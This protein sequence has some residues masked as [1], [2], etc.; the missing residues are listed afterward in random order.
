MWPRA[1]ILAPHECC[2]CATA[3]HFH[4]PPLQELTYN[5][6][7]AKYDMGTA[8]GHLAISVDEAAATCAAV[9]AAG[10]TV[11]RPAGPVLGGTTVIAF[12]RDPDGYSIELI[13]GR[14]TD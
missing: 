7:V 2:H 5:Y 9:A 4:V 8:F 1:C 6:G 10:Y 14:D 12:V 11:S 13:E 3:A